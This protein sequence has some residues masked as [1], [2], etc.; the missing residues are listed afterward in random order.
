MNIIIK[1]VMLAVAIILPFSGG[2]II[3]IIYPRKF[4]DPWYNSLIQPPYNPPGWV[5]PI[6]W[7]FLYCSIGI[8]SYLVYARLVASGKGFDQTAQIALASYAIQLALNWAWS[9]IFF[10]YHSLK[11]VS[12]TDLHDL[13]FF[14][15]LKI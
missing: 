11:W 12:Q 7:T 5:F 3:G 9:P 10:R 15:F 1:I 4:N 6:A 14:K 8:A 13:A 2:W